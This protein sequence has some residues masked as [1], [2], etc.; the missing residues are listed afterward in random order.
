MRKKRPKIVTI[1][2]LSLILSVANLAQALENKIFTESGQ[3]LSGQQWNVVE[4]YNDQTIV[5]ML[6]GWV[7]TVATYDVSTFNISGGQINTFNA[8][9][10]SAVNATG[11]DVFSLN[12]RDTSRINVTDSI[13]I[14]NIWTYE[15]G[16]VHV[17]GGIV[18]DIGIYESGTLHL[19]DGLVTDSLS[20]GDS[21]LIG[22]YGYDLQ[23]YDTQGTYGV[24]YVTGKWS[25][26]TD[27]TINLYGS[28]TYSHIYLHE[29][30]EPGT[31]AFVTAGCLL[32]RR[33]KK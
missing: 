4:V 27:F 32:F 33:E 23:K 30:P 26:Y 13:E 17:N 28:E 15:H 12:A 21:G 6:G 11:G 1:V 7:D 20:A 22:I 14:E 24:G 8:Y 19:F 18:A 2:S 29:I 31:L 3:I 5:D 25:N 16:E 10:S 9:E